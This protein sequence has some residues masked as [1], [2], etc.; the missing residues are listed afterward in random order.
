[1]WQVCETDLMKLE[2]YDRI[3]DLGWPEFFENFMKKRVLNDAPPELLPPNWKT[4]DA[5]G[6]WAANGVPVLSGGDVTTP[7]ELL[8]GSRSLVEFA[9][10]M[11]TPA[12]T[13]LTDTAPF[14]S[15]SPTQGRAA[16]R[17]PA[18]A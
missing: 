10:D 13:S 15:Q 1:M 16:P 3:L 9:S 2:D 17:T 8:C 6:E 14:L 7:I 5:R 4:I 18:P 11:R 12:R